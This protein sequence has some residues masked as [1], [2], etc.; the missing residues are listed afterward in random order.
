MSLASKG[1]QGARYETPKLSK[2]L[3]MREDDHRSI[4]QSYNPQRATEHHQEKR[5][6]RKA[7]DGSDSEGW[8]KLEMAV[9][10]ATMTIVGLTRLAPTAASPTT[11][12][13]TIP[14]VC[15]IGCQ[16]TGF[17]LLRAAP[18]RFP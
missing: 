5:P 9:R 8:R 11:R 18:A 17:P 4:H 2:A 1:A 10:A 6:G 12:P 16:R 3:K 15:P 7:S 14:M 13:P